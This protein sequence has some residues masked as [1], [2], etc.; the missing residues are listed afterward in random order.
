VREG[1]R[2]GGEDGRGDLNGCEVRARNGMG[3]EV[4]DKEEEI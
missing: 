1:G 3:E 2:E 4:A